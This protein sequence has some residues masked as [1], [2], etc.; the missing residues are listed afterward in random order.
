[1]KHTTV[2]AGITTKQTIAEVYA[3]ALTDGALAERL[4]MLAVEPSGWGK[5]NRDAIL[6]D[7]ILLEAAARLDK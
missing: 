5:V 4:R 1:M 7:A 6:R 3:K 2:R